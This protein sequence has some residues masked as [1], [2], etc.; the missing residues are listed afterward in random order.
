MILGH[1]AAIAAAL[2]INNETTVQN[3][4]YEMLKKELLNCQQVIYWSSEMEDDPIK[5]MEETFGE[6]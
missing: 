5:R 1:S 6:K 4:E 2:A 3:V